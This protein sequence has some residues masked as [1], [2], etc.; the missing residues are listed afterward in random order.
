MKTTKLE[1]WRVS[2]GMTYAEMGN[3]L[4]ASRQYAFQIC[5]SGVARVAN[6]L[7]LIYLSK[8]SLTLEDMLSPEDAKELA[9]EGFL[10]L[11]EGQRWVRDMVDMDSK[12]DADLII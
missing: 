5:Q 10:E 8:G 1:E 2:Q 7:K 4:G 12:D 9:D 3:I 11:S 6:L